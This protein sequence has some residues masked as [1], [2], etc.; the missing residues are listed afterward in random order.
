MH[1][2]LELEMDVL[3]DILGESAE[4][5]TANPW[6]NYG[7][8]LHRMREFGASIKEMDLIDESLL[9]VEQ[10]MVVCDML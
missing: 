10:M 3:D 8:P 5:T 6:L 1:S 7:E 9:T 2:Q 4:V